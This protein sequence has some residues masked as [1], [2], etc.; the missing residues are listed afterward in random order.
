MPQHPTD[1][2]WRRGFV[3]VQHSLLDVCQLPSY[4]MQVGRR[5]PFNVTA[6]NERGALLQARDALSF[7]LSIDTKILVKGP[8][9]NILF[10]ATIAELRT[11]F[12]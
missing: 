9:G 8:E 3:A 7:L 11:S 2:S 10:D 12:R 4:V 6:P 1:L 5:L